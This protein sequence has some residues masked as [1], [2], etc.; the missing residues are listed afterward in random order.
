MIKRKTKGIKMEF[1][2]NEKYN[3]WM[4][5]LVNLKIV[6]EINKNGREK[7]KDCKNWKEFK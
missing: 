2:K 7:K 5:R 4:K 6:K 3:I 1:I